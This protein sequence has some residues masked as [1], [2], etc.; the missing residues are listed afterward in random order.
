[1]NQYSEIDIDLHY[2]FIE[3]SILKYMLL[4]Q[5]Y[6]FISRNNLRPGCIKKFM[7]SK[8]L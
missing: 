8:I 4:M 6:F 2:F 1:M 3:I 5:K 7:L